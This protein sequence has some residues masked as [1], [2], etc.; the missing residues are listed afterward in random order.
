[1]RNTPA[2]FNVGHIPHEKR[3]LRERFGECH[4]GYFQYA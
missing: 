1:M 4:L 2:F 3:M